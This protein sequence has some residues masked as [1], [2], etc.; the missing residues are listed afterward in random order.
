MV[1]ENED[2]VSKWCL[3]WRVCAI[4]CTVPYLDILLNTKWIEP[5]EEGDKWK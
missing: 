5:L 1:L 3:K 4:G 2:S